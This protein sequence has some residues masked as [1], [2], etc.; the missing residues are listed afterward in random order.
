MIQCGPRDASFIIVHE[1]SIEDL[2]H[3]TLVGD[4]NQGGDSLHNV[5]TK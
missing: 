4:I 2:N 1:L 5:F 3:S